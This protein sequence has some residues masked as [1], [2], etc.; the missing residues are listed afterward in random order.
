MVLDVLR[1]SAEILIIIMLQAALMSWFPG[2]I[3][4]MPDFLVSTASSI[5]KNALLVL[6]NANCFVE[7]QNY[8]GNSLLL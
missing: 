1:Y 2:V 3:N 4:V 7:S 8:C 5:S 6:S